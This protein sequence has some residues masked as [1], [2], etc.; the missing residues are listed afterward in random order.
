MDQAEHQPLNTGFSQYPELHPQVFTIQRA[1]LIGHHMR[2]LAF[3]S[4]WD[5]KGIGMT[6]GG[7]LDND[8]GS[9]VCVEFIG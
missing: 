6:S 3:E 4:A 7:Q 8:E 9:D 2:I 1:E 5:S